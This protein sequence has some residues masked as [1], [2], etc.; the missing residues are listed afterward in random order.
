MLFYQ[1]SPSMT[2]MM[3]A[4]LVHV[5][6]YSSPIDSSFGLPLEEGTRY[7]IP[8][9]ISIKDTQRITGKQSWQGGP[10]SSKCEIRKNGR[11]PS[12]LIGPDHPKINQICL[13]FRQNEGKL[14]RINSVVFLSEFRNSLLI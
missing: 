11:K 3:P 14:T 6:G 12:N 4:S 2:A 5:T 9:K 1:I 8:P 7:L 13:S 10:F